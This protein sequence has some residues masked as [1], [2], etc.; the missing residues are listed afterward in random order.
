MRTNRNVQ[1]GKLENKEIRFK[2]GIAVKT[3][4]VDVGGFLV[5]TAQWDSMLCK[6][7]EFT[8]LKQPHPPK[9]QQIPHTV[10]L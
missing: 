7:K 6:K 8:C 1:A 3:N 9:K 10:L 2:F 4:A 5:F